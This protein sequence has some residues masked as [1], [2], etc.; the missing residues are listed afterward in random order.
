MIR[1]FR[2]SLTVILSIQKPSER[3]STVIGAVI[4]TCVGKSDQLRFSPERHS[5]ITYPVIQAAIG[6][7]Y[8]EDR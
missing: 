6:V 2:A 4:L 1:T 5:T 7:S 8:F 3:E